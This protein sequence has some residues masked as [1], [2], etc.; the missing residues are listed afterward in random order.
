[1]HLTEI[2]VAALGIVPFW[3][4]S[5]YNLQTIAVRPHRPD[6]MY[7]YVLPY[8]TACCPTVTFRLV[9]TYDCR[10][11]R[12][13]ARPA[14]GPTTA[15]RP[16][17]AHAEAAS[18]A[19]W[20]DSASWH[21]SSPHVTAHLVNPMLAGTLQSDQAQSAL[22]DPTGFAPLS[23]DQEYIFPPDLLLQ[24]LLPPSLHPFPCPCGFPLSMIS[25]LRARRHPPSPSHTRT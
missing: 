17:V 14:V 5:R 1:M 24:V 11:L 12:W 15:A 9:P 18:L 2:S 23:Q 8:T 20:F 4:D 22:A 25:V 21:D 6:Y 13:S 3:K 16:P 19:C 10:P 7:I